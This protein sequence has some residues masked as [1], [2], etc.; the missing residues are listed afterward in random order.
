MKKVISG[1]GVVLLLACASA[2]P[3]F[4]DSKVGSFRAGVTTEAQAIRLLG[5]EPNARHYRP[6][7]S[8]VAAWSHASASPFGHS[9]KSLGVLFDAQAVMV[10]ITSRSHTR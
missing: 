5:A 8:Y 2:G 6:D 10:R 7:G 1:V 9:V 3:N 4:D